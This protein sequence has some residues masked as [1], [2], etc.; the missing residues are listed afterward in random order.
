MISITKELHEGAIWDAIKNAAT[1]AGSEI[2]S[3]GSS[4]IKTFQTPTSNNGF[5][6]A[7]D[8]LGQIRSQISVNKENIHQNLKE[9]GLN[10]ASK[11]LDKG[12]SLVNKG[13]EELNKKAA[14][15]TPPQAPKS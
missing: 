10:V 3:R 15:T 2:K 7:K 12:Q 6:Q 9:R 13:R 8:A 11:I 14:G 4:A 1:S 5:A